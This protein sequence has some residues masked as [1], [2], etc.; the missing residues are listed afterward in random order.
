MRRTET[1]ADEDQALIS[2]IAAGSEAALKDFYL[3]YENKLYNF[4][5]ARLNDSFD[6]SDIVNEVMLEVWRSAT[7]FEGRSKVSTWFF[8]IAHHKIVDKLRKK[9]NRVVVEFDDGIEDDG[10]D[11]VMAIEGASNSDHVKHCMDRLS[12]EHRQIIHLAFF[13]DISYPEI[14]EIVDCP[15]GTVKSRIHHAKAA[16]KRCLEIRMRRRES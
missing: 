16:L 1:L 8:G 11:V 7:R 4:A 3:R 5:Y 15:Q 9:G 6:A 2:R 10:A 13:E 12:D 14:S